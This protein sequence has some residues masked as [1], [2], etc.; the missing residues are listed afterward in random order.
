MIPGA[1]HSSTQTL[2]TV[3]HLMTGEDRGQE[4]TKGCSHAG[5]LQA[6]LTFPGGE[7]RPGE[8][9]AL[10]V[11][12]LDIEAGEFGEADPQGAA[13]V[14]DVLSV[15]GLKHMRAVSAPRGH[16]HPACVSCSRLRPTSLAAWAQAASGYCSRAWN[17]LFL[18]N[19]MIFSTEPN[20]EKICRSQRAS[21]C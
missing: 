3:Q 18:V 8:V 15:Q 14:V 19:T 17:W 2:A 11:V 20:L 16:T 4:L 10:L 5:G 13:A 21:R 12:V 7:V 1:A 6:G 9:T